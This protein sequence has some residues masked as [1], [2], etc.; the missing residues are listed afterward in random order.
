MWTCISQNFKDRRARAAH[1]GLTVIGEIMP[2][3]FGS[4]RVFVISL[5]QEREIVAASDRQI[6]PRFCKHRVSARGCAPRMPQ[7][8]SALSFVRRNK[9]ASLLVFCVTCGFEVRLCVS[10]SRRGYGEAPQ[11]RFHEILREVE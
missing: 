1:F 9:I 7:A 5:K 3:V 4:F 2:P 8:C 10:G 6:V 11:F